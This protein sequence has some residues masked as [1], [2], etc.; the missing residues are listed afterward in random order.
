MLNRYGALIGVVFGL[1]CKLPSPRN[2]CSN[3]LFT[4]LLATVEVGT[5]DS[6]FTVSFSLWPTQSYEVDICDCEVAL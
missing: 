1:M 4:H 6:T 3:R 5:K 2:L